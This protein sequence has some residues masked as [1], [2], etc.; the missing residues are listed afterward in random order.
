[1]TRL[2]IGATWASLTPAQQQQVTEAFRHY[3]AATYADRFDSFSGE[4]LQVTGERPYNGDVIV[5]T[6]IINSKGEPTTLN[7]RM[8]R[9]QGPWQISLSRRHDQPARS[10]RS[11]FNAVLPRRNRWPDRGV[12]PQRSLLGRSRQG[13]IARRLHRD[14]TALPGPRLGLQFRAGA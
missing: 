6:K 12:E 13:G 2:S 11:E 1:M 10:H 5:E 8:S 4:Q 3:V 7:Y 9:R 14:R